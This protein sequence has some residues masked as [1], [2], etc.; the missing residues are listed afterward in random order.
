MF[1]PRNIALAFILSWTTASSFGYES[2]GQKFDYEVMSQ[3]SGVIWGFDFLNDGRIIFTE[4][5]GKI[6]IFDPKTKAVSVV[7]GA[8]PVWAKG[9]GGLLDVRVHP[10][11]KSKIYLSYV[12]PIE[13]GG[14]TALAMAELRGLELVQFKKFFSAIKW[15]EESEHF[16][17]RIEFDR[18]GHLFA[19]IGERQARDQV[20]A[21][22]FHTGKIIRLNE[23]GSIP[24]D[25][26]YVGKSGTKPEIWSRGHRNQQGLVMNHETGEL[27]EAEMGPQGGDEINLIKREG[28]YGWP[29][30]T[31]G[32]EYSGPK[33][34]EGTR[35]VGMEDP[36]VYW[37]PSI[38]PSAVTLYTGNAFPKWKGS[39]FVGTLSGTHLRRIVMNEKKVSTQEELLKD[40]RLRIRNVRTGPEGF[41]YLSTD[42][43]KIARLKPS[44]P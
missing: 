34:G 8:P 4:R 2:E 30:V 10:T 7:K 41:L 39:L 31:Y 35:K 23:N 9:Q 25:N 27:W 44:V 12:E 13:T 5:E 24:K 28:N 11:E 15:N 37:V 26:P 42:D 38:S 21:L 33:I 18:K 16:G 36:V 17:S 32:R 19:T 1:S 20:Q 29:V 14:T 6:K 3:T 40:L 43:G 22:D